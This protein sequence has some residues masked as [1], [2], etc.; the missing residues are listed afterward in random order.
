MDMAVMLFESSS[1]SPKGAMLMGPPPS[2][3]ETE[4]E[5]GSLDEVPEAA[6]KSTVKELDT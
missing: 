1:T 5:R 4:A 2:L 3:K 6:S